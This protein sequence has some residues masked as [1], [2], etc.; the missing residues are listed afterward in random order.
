LTDAL[1]EDRDGLVSLTAETAERLAASG[2]A[3]MRATKALLNELDGSL[4]EALAMRCAETSA[5]V[6]TGPEAQARIQ[7]R[8]G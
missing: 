2:P 5:D 8:F 1:A 4:D 6:F 7:A 3:A